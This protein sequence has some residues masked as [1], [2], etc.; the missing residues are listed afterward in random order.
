MTL[1]HLLIE[2]TC[3]HKDFRELSLSISKLSLSLLHYQILS[4]LTKCGIKTGY[5]SSAGLLDLFR[6]IEKVV[7]LHLGCHSWVKYAFGVK[8]WQV[9][10]PRLAR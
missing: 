2:T 10:W 8:E 9:L 1:K 7:L 5:T 3:I 4:R 6:Y